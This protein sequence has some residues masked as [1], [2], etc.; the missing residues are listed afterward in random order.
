MCVIA[1]SI[2]FPLD[3][4][5][6]VWAF[7]LGIAFLLSAVLYTLIF[8]HSMK[9]SIMDVEK[10]ILAD[11]FL[12]M[13]LPI[14]IAEVV[15]NA[16]G[17]VLLWAVD[18]K[19]GWTPLA[20]M[21]ACIW[22]HMFMLF[23]CGCL[24]TSSH[25][26]SEGNPWLLEEVLESAEDHEKSVHRWENRCRSWCCLFRVVTCNLFGGGAMEAGDA[27]YADVAKVMSQ[28][29]TGLDLV[30][31]DL[32]AALCLVVSNHTMNLKLIFKYRVACGAACEGSCS[33]TSHYSP[34]TPSFV[35]L[36]L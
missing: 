2:Q 29:F 33:S 24:L 31:S 34:C 5:V 32:I 9:G 23:G 7:S 13:T 1:F 10:R 19:G 36:S 26:T 30:P 16:T 12:K 25:T 3:D 4:A 11:T 8:I 15:I 6:Q 18:T 20:I 35:E 27:T 14:L 22:M 21:N 28:F 17:T